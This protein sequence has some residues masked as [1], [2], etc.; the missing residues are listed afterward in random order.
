MTNLLAWLRAQRMALLTTRRWFIPVLLIGA[1]VVGSFVVG[2]TLGRR[3]GGN[4]QIAVVTKASPS[5]Q[6]LSSATP[7]PTPSPSPTP[8]PTPSPAPSPAAPVQPS[9]V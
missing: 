1:I 6:S 9:P 7:T 3:L 8:T 2:A 5:Q 4:S